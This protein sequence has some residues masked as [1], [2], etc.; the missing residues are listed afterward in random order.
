[1]AAVH[2][3][4][5][6]LVKADVPGA[7]DA[8]Q[9]QV[10]PPQVV[11]QP[12]VV[13]ADSV[14]VHRHA[15][16]DM[17]VS[18][19]DIDMVEKVLPHVTVVALGVLGRQGAVLVQINAAHSRKVHVAFVVPVNQLPVNAQG[20]RSRRQSQHTGG[21]QDDLGGYYI[22]GLAAHI[23][24]IGGLNDLHCFVSLFLQALPRMDCIPAG[25]SISGGSNS[26]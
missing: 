3:L 12:V 5:A 16:R 2:K 9:L 11:D 21:E 8:E 13:G 23:A 25:Y 19:Q 10:D 4:V 20:R 18:G 17:N 26:T 24:V 22:C 7:A 1:M 15:V 14:A 6:G